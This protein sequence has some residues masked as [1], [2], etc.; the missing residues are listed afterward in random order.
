MLHTN[1][2]ECRLREN[3]DTQTMR[4]KGRLF[5]FYPAQWPGRVIP[6][7]CLDFNIMY[8][9]SS[10]INVDNLVTIYPILLSG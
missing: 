9:Q 5:K 10:V 4:M 2:F 6:H 8:A 1:H 3:A 7:S